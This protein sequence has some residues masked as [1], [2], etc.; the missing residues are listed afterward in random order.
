VAATGY[1]LPDIAMVDDDSDDD[2]DDEEEEA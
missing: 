2:S 1:E